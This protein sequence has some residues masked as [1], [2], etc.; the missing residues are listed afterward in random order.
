[1]NTR[2][3]GNDDSRKKESIYWKLGEV[4]KQSQRE[5]THQNSP[6]R[7]FLGKMSSNMQD[8]AEDHLQLE[9]AIQKLLGTEYPVHKII[10]KGYPEIL[11]D[12][13]LLKQKL[14]EKEN[15]DNR[16]EAQSRKRFNARGDEAFEETLL[17]KEER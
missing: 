16:Y 3:R 5:L 14:K 10:S 9:T 17:L 11:K 4:M 1:M 2:R 12:R 6:L 7:D 15:V 8:L 13:D